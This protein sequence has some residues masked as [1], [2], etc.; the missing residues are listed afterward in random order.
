MNFAPTYWLIA[1]AVI[2]I[3]AIIMTI[4]GWRNDR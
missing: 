1:C 4:W 3:F 2:G